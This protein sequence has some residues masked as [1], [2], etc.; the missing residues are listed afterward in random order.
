MLKKGGRLIMVGYQGNTELKIAT[1]KMVLDELEL[2]ESRYCNTHDLRDTV[3]LVYQGI[4]K[5][6]VGKVLPL[7]IANEGLDML[8]QG[9]LNGRV[10]LII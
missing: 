8:R 4:I 5:P 3:D 9:Q 1:Q 10:V 6:V 7:E 2:L